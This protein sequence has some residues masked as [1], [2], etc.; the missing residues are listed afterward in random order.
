MMPDAIAKA[1]EAHALRQKL[2]ALL[3]GLMALSPALA[4][5]GL[6]R[7]GVS[8]GAILRDLATREPMV[9]ANG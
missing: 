3:G 7:A 2:L 4:A 9:P 1:R 8:E 6:L 5:K